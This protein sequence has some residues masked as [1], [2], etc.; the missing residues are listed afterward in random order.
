MTILKTKQKSTMITINLLVAFLCTAI[1]MLSAAGFA[2]A[3]NTNPGNGKRDFQRL[4]GRWVRPDGG[5]VLELLSIKKDGSVSASY[6]NPTPIKVYRAEAKKKNG[7]ITLFVE[8]RD[9]NY[10]GSTY[11]LIYD[12]AT[13]RLKGTYFQAVHKQTFYVEF[14]RAR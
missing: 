5:Y 14:V 13:D 10:P 12:S 7:R 3:G 6:F 8:L 11:N 9:I 4:E 2:S 1:L